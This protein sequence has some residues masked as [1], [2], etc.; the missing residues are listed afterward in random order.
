MTD[1][2]PDVL[3]LCPSRGSAVAWGSGALLAAA[4]FGWTV[5]DTDGNPFAV[6]ALVF[7]VVVAAYFVLQAVVPERFTVSFDQ[8]GLTSRFLSR[9]IEVA[10]EQVHVARVGSLA[11]EPYLEL[12][13]RERSPT[14]DPWRTRATGVV[15]PVG[16]DVEALHRFL[17]A[18]L[19][20]GGLR[21]PRT[22][23]PI[24]LDEERR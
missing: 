14:G 17:S 4:V 18:R 8:R 9:R 23:T 13:I 16:C 24:E 6:V 1:G 15:L 7:A 20:R 12:H 2:V 22:V 19:G 21:P 3:E 10:W 11:G 5:F